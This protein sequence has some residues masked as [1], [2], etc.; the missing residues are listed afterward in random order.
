MPF[1]YVL[2][3][4]TNVLVAD[5]DPILREFASVDPSSP[6]AEIVTVAD[7]AEAL[8]AL[9]PGRFDILL[10]D[11]ERPVMNGFE[12]LERLRADPAMA[13]LPVMVLAVSKYPVAEGE[14]VESMVECPEMVIGDEP[15]C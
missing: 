10:L 12:V 13:G 2:D 3:E 7:G 4:R 6:A 15:T 8:A 9:A 11:L 1:F 14:T 5:D